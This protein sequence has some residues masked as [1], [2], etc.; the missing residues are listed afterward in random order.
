MAD[1]PHCDHNMSLVAVSANLT[2][3]YWCSQCG[4]V[5]DSTDYIA[6][7]PE[8][9]KNPSQMPII[10]EVTA[11]RHGAGGTG[12]WVTGAVLTEKRQTGT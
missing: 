10:V 9:A 4:T 6:R 2:S 5:M 8:A 3:C 1:C 12:V 7:V 11:C